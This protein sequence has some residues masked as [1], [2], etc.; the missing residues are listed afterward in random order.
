ML[1]RD[2][3]NRKA[4][5]NNRILRK[6]N[7]HNNPRIMMQKNIFHNSYYYII[8]INVQRTDLKNIT[9]IY[10]QYCWQAFASL[11]TSW[12][13]QWCYIT[14]SWFLGCQIRKVTTNDLFYPFHTASA[15]QTLH[16][17]CVSGNSE[18][19]NR[20]KV[21]VLFLIANMFLSTHRCGESW[22]WH[23]FF[24]DFYSA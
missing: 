11:H 3:G 24:Y 1:L 14:H 19:H 21:R 9:Y 17:T 18:I 10:P 13:G 16:T 23:D 4:L 6:L 22:G 2:A 5:P 15:P 8:Y 20:W 12:E 7:H